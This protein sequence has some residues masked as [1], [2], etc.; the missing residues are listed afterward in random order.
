MIRPKLHI[1]DFELTEYGYE[2]DMQKPT[3]PLLTG[4]YN[5]TLKVENCNITNVR[6]LYRIIAD[7]LKVESELIETT[8]KEGKGDVH[9]LQYGVKEFLQNILKEM[10]KTK[11]IDKLG[12]YTIKSR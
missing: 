11:K 4:K 2:K 10:K 8:E 12:Y 5:F 3:H 1:T 6:I 9:P 7:Q